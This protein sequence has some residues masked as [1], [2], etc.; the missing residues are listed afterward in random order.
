MAVGPMAALA[1]Q[2]QVRAE[3]Q[4]VLPRVPE[5]L[6]LQVVVQV[7]EIPQVAVVLPEASSSLSQARQCCP[8]HQQ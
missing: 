1:V 8:Q 7:E 3:A 6:H 5:A 2:E 4:E